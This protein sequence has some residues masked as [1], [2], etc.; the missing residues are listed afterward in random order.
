MISPLKCQHI[1]VFPVQP[2]TKFNCI[3]QN[4]GASVADATAG[5]LAPRDMDLK[6]IVQPT[7]DGSPA[8]LAQPP[9]N[10]RF[11]V[12]L[13]FLTTFENKSGRF[14]RPPDPKS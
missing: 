1:F 12:T 13:S 9:P 11:G 2:T 4:K 8:N 7:L 6:C 14:A 10:P 3:P 5:I